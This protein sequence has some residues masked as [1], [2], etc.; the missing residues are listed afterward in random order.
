MELRGGDSGTELGE[1]KG[2]EV[3]AACRK[4]IGSFRRRETEAEVAG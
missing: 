1:S 2:E 3:E 4:E